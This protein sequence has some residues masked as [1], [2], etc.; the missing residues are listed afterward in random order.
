MHLLYLRYPIAPPWDIYCQ[1]QTTI[2]HARTV[3]VPIDYAIMLCMPMVIKKTCCQRLLRSHIAKVAP[4]IV[5]QR[6]GRGD[7]SDLHSTPNQTL[8]LEL[9]RATLICVPGV[10]IHVGQQNREWH[11][12]PNNMNSTTQPTVPNSPMQC[13]CNTS[14]AC[15]IF[16]QRNRSHDT[17]F[18]G[19]VTDVVVCILLSQWVFN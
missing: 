13:K 5:Q 9:H 12:N 2:Q 14:H 3:H 11:C 6:Y 7:Q 4:S 19:S 16:P 8:H 17:W 15:F 10:S 18:S 1:R